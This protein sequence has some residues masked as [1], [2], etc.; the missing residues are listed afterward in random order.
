MVRKLDKLN[1]YQKLHKIQ[2]EIIA[3]GKDKSTGDHRSSY[4]YVTGDK[5]L[6]YVKPLMNKY[7]L[8]LKQEATSIE[9]EAIEYKV[10]TG[11][12]VEMLYSIWQKFT[13]IDIETGEKDENS[14]FATGMNNW[15]KGVG[16]AYTYAE[17][18]FLL[19]FFHIAT[20]EDDID[21][22]AR[23]KEEEIAEVKENPI[24]PNQL[25]RINILIKDAGYDTSDEKV[26]SM[27]YGWLEIESL[28]TI[29][30]KKAAEIIIKLQK[31]ID[32]K[33]QNGGNK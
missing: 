27:M 11:T 2:N 9:K 1:L 19:K 18:Y 16:S 23:K 5:L 20:D 21:N 31:A 30:A 25:K 15:E 29:S 13:W 28:K 4:K 12:K 3:L 32:K 22:S 7:G 8:M 14:F 6:G 26:K 17:R 33:K 24:E 10:K